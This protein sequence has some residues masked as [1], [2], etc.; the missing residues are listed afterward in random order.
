[1]KWAMLL[2]A[3]IADGTVVKVIKRMNKGGKR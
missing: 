1:M 3:C 2:A